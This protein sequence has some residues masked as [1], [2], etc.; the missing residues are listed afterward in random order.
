M[1]TSIKYH[2]NIFKLIGFIELVEIIDFFIEYKLIPQTEIFMTFARIN[3]VELNSESEAD[4]FISNF[5]SG[6]LR[7]I[8]PEAEILIS[9]RTGPSS[10]TSV[11]VYKNKRTADSVAERRNSTIEGLK[12]LI[13]SLALTEGKVEILDLKKDSGVGTF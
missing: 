1:I 9:I 11:S 8:F 10:V 4:T 5:T 3:N 2:S 12:S 13:K 6:K 7:E